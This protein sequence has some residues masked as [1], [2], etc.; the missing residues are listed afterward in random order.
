MKT[1]ALCLSIGLAS[2]IAAPF[3]AA[4]ER[5]SRDEQKLELTAAALDKGAARPEGEKAV[6]ERLMAEFKVDDARV[7]GLRDQKLGY[8]EIC[9][10]LA[11]AQKMPGGITDAN[12]RTI[13]SERRGPPAMGWGRIAEKRRV[14][15]G[16]VMNR[17]R[18]VDAAVEKRERAEGS[19]RGKMEKGERS[20]RPERPERPERIERQERMERPENPRH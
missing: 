13:L 18:R 4:E 10:A 6:Q 16:S 3:A 15:L 14:K 8:G 2:F 12:I 7:R 17:V 20:E 9:I 19:N 1:K 5:P 11:L